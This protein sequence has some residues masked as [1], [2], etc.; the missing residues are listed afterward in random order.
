MANRDFILNFKGKFGQFGGCFAPELLYPVISKIENFFY[1]TFI[2]SK[3]LNNEFE[4]ILKNYCGRETPLYFAENLTQYCGGG[5][6]Y[7]K[8]EDLSFTGS[9]KIN[10]VAGQILIAKA[11]GFC[12]IICETGAGQHGVATAT[13]GAKF[14]IKVKV[15]MG[16][17]D[18]KRQIENVTKMKLLNA[19][20]VSVD[21]GN[22]TLKDAVNKAMQ[23][24]IANQE[25]SYYLLGSAV[26]PHPFPSMVA[27]F[28]YIVGNEA[29]QQILKAENCLP[30][31]VI[32]CVGGGSNAI[33]IFQ[34]FIDENV[35][36]IA[37][38]PGGDGKNL[39]GMTLKHGK[40]G[41]FHGM[42]TKILTDENG[43]INPSHSISAGLD[44][45]SISPIHAYL[46]NQNLIN[47]T[48]STDKKAIDAFKI[49]TKLEGIIPA[50][51]S[52][53]AIAETIEIAQKSDKKEIIIT[54]LSGG[55]YKDINSVIKY[56]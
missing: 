43:N 17:K 39:H 2:K 38:E 45:P 16:E 14:N 29:R 20:I 3:D 25:K 13:M 42:M 34:S 22:G 52:A 47:A 37:V 54:N 6:I 27:Y 40:I 32:A 12:E 44:Y 48:S 50:L 18:I 53:H 46:L 23:Y 7:L 21:D 33:G 9:H 26:G 19:E 55:G 4:D 30:N 36:L 56:E 31:F 49:L 41:C 35:K 11:M 15:F 1:N 10:N 51:E 5:K 8:R 28:Q 24:W